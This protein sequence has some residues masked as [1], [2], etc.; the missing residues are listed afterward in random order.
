VV[1]HRRDSETK[2][3]VLADQLLRINREMALVV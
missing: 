2:A 1:S 3:R